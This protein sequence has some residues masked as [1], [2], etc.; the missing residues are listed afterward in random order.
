MHRIRADRS[1]PLHDTRAS[2]ELERLAQAQLP[3]HTLMERAGLSCARLARAI[4]PHARRVWI[5]CG[6]GNNG[7]DGFEAAWQLHRLGW[8]VTLTWTGSPQEPADA[9]TA[10]KKALAAGLQIAAQPPA[11]FDLGIDALLGLAGDL[12]HERPATAQMRQHLALMHAAPV[13]VLAVD[14]PTGLHGDSGD[15]PLALAGSSQRHTLS[16]LSLKPG[17][18]TAQ[19]RDQAGQVW[20]D[21]LGVNPAGVPASA[22]LC[23]ADQAGRPAPAPHASHKGSFGDVIVIGGQQSASQTG[24]TGAALLAARAALHQG[25]GRV[26]VCLLG[27]P[28]LRVDAMQPELMFRSAETPWDW[29][30][31]QVAVVGCGGGQAVAQVLPEVLERSA[32]M[33]LDADGLNAVACDRRLRL[34]LAARERQGLASVLTPHPLEAA[35]LLGATT[36]AVQ[37]DRLHAAQTLADELR[38][39][40]VLKGSGTVVAAPGQ[41][42]AINPSG[43]ALLATAGTGDVLAGMVGAALS[44]GR[45]ARSAALHAVHLHG[46]KADAWARAHPERLLCASDLLT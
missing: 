16:L 32:R 19:G 14:L 23:G 28:D 44:R 18:F 39:V 27:Q 40:V 29:Q 24:M 15:S 1:W 33:V 3:P 46:A 22:L 5:A 34:A 37:T 17:L 2:R 36:N 8:Q 6:P 10:R 43:N 41:V 42:P 45:E 4:A 20:F 25:A 12:T 38:C 7:G 35:R 26:Y 11:Q 30:P 13:P 31:G 21:D 9:R